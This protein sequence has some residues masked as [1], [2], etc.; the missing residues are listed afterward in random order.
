[1]ADLTA[2]WEQLVGFVTALM[3]ENRQDPGVL[4]AHFDDRKLRLPLPGKDTV[5]AWF[6]FQISEPELVEGNLNEVARRFYAEYRAAQ[7]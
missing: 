7:Q 4:E 5:H 6:S 1:M 3:N 2:R